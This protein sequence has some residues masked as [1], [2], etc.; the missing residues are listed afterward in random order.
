MKKLIL[1]IILLALPFSTHAQEQNTLPKE[2]LGHWYPLSKNAGYIALNIHENGKIDNILEN[3]KQPIEIMTYRYIMSLTDKNVSYIIV[4]FEVLPA[5]NTTTEIWQLRTEK[6]GILS[7]K[8][9][10]NIVLFVNSKDCGL[11]T[12]SFKTLSDSDLRDTVTNKCDFRSP[13][14]EGNLATYSRPIGN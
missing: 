1:I 12:D 7:P 4:K 6:D 11:S 9:K 2:F 13:Y 10:K 14:N 8:Y 3:K 5:P